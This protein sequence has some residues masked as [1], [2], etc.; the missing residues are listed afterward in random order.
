M[1]LYIFP[2]NLLA[3]MSAFVNKLFELVMFVQT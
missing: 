3:G 1:Y 2:P